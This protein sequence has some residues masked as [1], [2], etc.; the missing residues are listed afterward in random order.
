MIVC[1]AGKN[2]IAVK[3][4][5][6]LVA[7]QGVAFEICVVVNSDDRGENTWQESL[8]FT[9]LDLGIKV[10][11]L[12]DLDLQTSILTACIIYIFQ[13]CRVTVAHQQLS[14]RF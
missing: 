1:I 4:L 5:R 7:Y 6:R 10:L 9:A 13:L 8:K 2:D 11:T 14:G 12:D 3:V